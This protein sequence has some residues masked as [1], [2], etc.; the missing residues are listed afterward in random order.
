MGTNPTFGDEPRSVE[1]FV[2]DEEADLYGHTATVEFVA[3]LRPMVKFHGVE[4][5]LA[6]MA[7]DVSR[8]REILAG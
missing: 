8:A 1:S 6:A 3:R 5:L 4:E 2:I 7:Q